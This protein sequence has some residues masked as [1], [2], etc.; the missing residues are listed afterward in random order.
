MPAA[1]N[2]GIKIKTIK[3]AATVFI[4]QKNTDI[5]KIS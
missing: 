5:A 4:S 3:P 2:A 1:A